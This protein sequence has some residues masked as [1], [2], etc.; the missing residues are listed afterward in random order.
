MRCFIAI[1][2]DAAMKSGVDGVIRDLKKG[3]WDVGW[4]RAENLHLTLKFLGEVSADA[5]TRLE[6]GLSVAASGCDPF[7]MRLQGTGVFPDRKRPRIVWIDMIEP[8]GSLLKLQELIEI[9][10]ES[11]GFAPEDRKFSPHLTIGRIKSARGKEELIKEI[12]ALNDKDFGNIHVDGFSLMKSDLRPSGAQYTS[13]KEF[14][15]RKEN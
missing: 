7:E 14:L 4:I 12:E 8:S 1:N 2:L 5:M 11:L 3:D 15:F 6:K 13:L 10:T 9:S